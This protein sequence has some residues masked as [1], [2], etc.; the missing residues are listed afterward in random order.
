MAKYLNSPEYNKK[1]PKKMN[2]I[3]I[4]YSAHLWNKMIEIGSGFIMEM[5]TYIKKTR[6]KILTFLNRFS[7]KWKFR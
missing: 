2:Y 1:S 6:D 5:Q 7:Y 4:F 3:L